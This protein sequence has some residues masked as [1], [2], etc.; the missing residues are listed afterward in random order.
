MAKETGLGWTALN[1]DDAAG[2]PRDLRNDMTNLDFAT[3][4]NVH[5]VT[6]IDKFATERLLLLAD[7][8]GTLNSVFNPSANRVHSVMAGNLR[9]ARTLGITIS[10]QILNNEVLFTDYAL[11]RAAGGEFTAQHPFVLSDGTVPTWTV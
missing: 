1:V 4:Y 11:T 7:F 5:E 2:T 10:A 6:G 8:S 9:V 3:P